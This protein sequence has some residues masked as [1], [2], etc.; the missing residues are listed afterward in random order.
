MKLSFQPPEEDDPRGDDQRMNESDSERPRC[1]TRGMI[2]PGV[3]CGAVIVGGE[4]C[5]SSKECQ[6]KLL[7]NTGVER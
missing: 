6:H 7:P 5:G 1:A 4:F 3:M 2:R